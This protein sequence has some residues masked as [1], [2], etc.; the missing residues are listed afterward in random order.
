MTHISQQAPPCIQSL[1]VMHAV[2]NQVT[3]KDY[4]DCTR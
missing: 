2:S 1:N 3:A 4:T